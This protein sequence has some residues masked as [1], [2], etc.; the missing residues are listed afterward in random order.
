[1]ATSIILAAQ[2]AAGQTTDVVVTTASWATLS[3]FTTDPLGVVGEVSLAIVQ[4]CA[5][6]SGV[7]YQPV[8][9]AGAENSQNSFITKYQRQ[10]FL[11]TPG[12]YAVSKG[13]TVQL[14]GVQLDQ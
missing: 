9:F 11:D 13:P 10:V 4:K 2:T 3:I 14:I 6:T 7:A 12:V 5:V 8:S 1:M